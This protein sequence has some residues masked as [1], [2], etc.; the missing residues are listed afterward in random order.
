[1]RTHHPSRPSWQAVETWA[2]RPEMILGA[3]VLVGMLL[4]E[5][6]QSSR[7]TQLCLALDQT[8]SAC[9]QANARCDYLRAAV[10]RST[11]RAELVP[12][13]GELGLAPADAGQIVLLPSAYLADDG[14]PVARDEGSVTAL[15]WAERISSALVPDATARGRG[16][17]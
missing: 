10:E 7:M 14:R 16:N 11:T 13:A 15:A 9:V 1:M 6:W 5:V 12:L 17:D 8:R 4:V 2:P 3:A